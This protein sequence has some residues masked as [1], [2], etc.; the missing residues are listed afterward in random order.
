MYLTS[1]QLCNEVK[2]NSDLHKIMY[3][4][5]HKMSNR[6]NILEMIDNF[7]ELSFILL[8]QHFSRNIW[9]KILFKFKFYYGVPTFRSIGCSQSV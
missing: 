9:N 1:M 3:K 6:F 8:N 2:R 5:R 4:T 7:P